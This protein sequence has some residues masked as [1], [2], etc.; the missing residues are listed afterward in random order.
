MAVLAALWLLLASSRD[1]V[2]RRSI[3]FA[4]CLT[5]S[6]CQSTWLRYCHGGTVGSGRK[7]AIAETCRGNLQGT[8]SCPQSAIGSVPS[9]E[10]GT[11]SR[12][13]S[14][15]PRSPAGR[16]PARSSRPASRRTSCA[17]S[18]SPDRGR[19]RRTPQR[20]IAR[21]AVRGLDRVVFPYRSL[22]YARGFLG[23][24]L[25]HDVV[26]NLGR[27]AVLAADRVGVDGGGGG[28]RR[29]AEAFADGRN[30]HASFQQEGRVAVAHGMER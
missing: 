3:D 21:P 10:R 12:P 15:S 11:P 28:H 23:A 5:L 19:T 2:P 30:V 8:L 25:L 16:S 14:P 4:N 17:C 27:G 1:F 22:V 20:G 6:L 7:T 18:P 26:P 13:P 24:R 29:V 9:A